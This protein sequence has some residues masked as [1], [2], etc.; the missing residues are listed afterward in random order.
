M[1]KTSFI[2]DLI[3][4]DEMHCILKE[5]FNVTHDELR[6]WIKISLD[7]IKSNEIIDS[8]DTIIP[9]DDCFNNGL[10]L[11]FPYISDLPNFNNCYDISPEGFFYPKYCFYDKQAVL[12]FKPSFHL[13]FIYK[14]DLTG[15]RNWNY[16]KVGVEDSISKILFKTHEHGILRFY[17]HNIDEFILFGKKSKLFC[18]TFD[19]ESYIENPESFFLLYDI[20]NV[21]RI[22][23][24]KDRQICLNELGIELIDLPKNV[25]NIKNVKG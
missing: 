15:K 24:G 25:I 19:A 23:L 12:Q 17:D 13:R 2:H 4:Y 16:Y 9:I 8:G 11:L 3:P 1:N 18:H 5:K 10:Y 20:L 21:E 22:F 14:K 7:F 6:F